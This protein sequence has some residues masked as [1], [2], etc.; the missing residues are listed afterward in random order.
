MQAGDSERLDLGSDRLTELWNAAPDTD[1]F[2]RDP[3]R[4][5]NRLHDGW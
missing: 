2:L 1:G 4:L 5:S 3:E